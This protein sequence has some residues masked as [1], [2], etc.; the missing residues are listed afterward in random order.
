MSK[1]CS[2]I[3]KEKKP[4]TKGGKY[5]MNGKFYCHIHYPGNK[6]DIKSKTT[7]KAKSKAAYDDDEI[8]DDISNILDQESGSVMTTTFVEDCDLSEN[9]NYLLHPDKISNV[10]F[11]KMNFMNAEHAYHFMK[12]WYPASRDMQ[13]GALA[14]AKEIY[15]S[16]S[17][18]NIRSL[19]EKNKRY[20]IEKWN[21]PDSNSVTYGELVMFSILDKARVSST[22]MFHEKLA[23]LSCD[24]TDSDEVVTRHVPQYHKVLKSLS[25]YLRSS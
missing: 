13:K 6:D 11:E 21:I 18:P 7:S 12:F 5:E 3:T 4:C 1:P 15:L 16:R 9:K 8:N 14:A 22:S 19:A 2:G 24:F 17:M 25:N 23:S 20:V 10:F